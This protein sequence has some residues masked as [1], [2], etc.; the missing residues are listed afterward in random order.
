MAT[1]RKSGFVRSRRGSR[2]GY[3]LAR[4]MAE[5]T[6]R[7]VLEVLEGPVEPFYCIAEP[8]NCRFSPACSIRDL[9]F[10]VKHAVEEVLETTTLADLCRNQ[11]AKQAGSR[12]AVFHI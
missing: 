7:E 9:M 5:I 4:P 2:G 11:K 6:V 3:S 1:L 10:R 12:G 8:G